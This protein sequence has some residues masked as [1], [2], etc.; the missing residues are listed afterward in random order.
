[1]LLD[2]ECVPLSK[3]AVIVLTF[4]F[5]CIQYVFLLLM[6]GSRHP[7]VAP[8]VTVELSYSLKKK[9]KKALRECVAT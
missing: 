5:F 6:S 3:T 7:R 9:K 2:I 1:M 4:S 8:S